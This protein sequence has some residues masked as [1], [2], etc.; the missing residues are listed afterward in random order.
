MRKIVALLCI[1]LLAACNLPRPASSQT[2]PPEDHSFTV[3]PLLLTTTD[4]PSS[5]NCYFNWATHPLPDLT[6]QLQ[7]SV[8]SGG[9]SEVT[10]TAEAFGEDC[11]DPVTNKAI[12]FGAMET[13]FRFAVQVNNLEDTDIQG[14]M[15]EKLLIVLDDFTKGSIHMAPPGYVNVSFTF[16]EKANYLSFLMKDAK[17]A[18]E[19]GLHGAE[20]YEQLQKK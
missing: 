1:V 8:D 15:L 11:I 13:D 20:L 7:A 2:V 9:L 10:A 16:G 5:Q 17:A 12:G 19:K 6:K 4:T 18:L 14:R 3:Q